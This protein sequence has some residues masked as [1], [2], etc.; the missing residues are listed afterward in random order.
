M[1]WFLFDK[2]LCHERGIDNLDQ[3]VIHYGINIFKM[4]ILLKVITDKTVAR[5]RSIK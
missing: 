4:D 1:D 2:N 5:A 3:V